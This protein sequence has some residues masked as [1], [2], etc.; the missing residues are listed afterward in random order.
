[1][2]AT[3][4]SELTTSA[5]SSSLARSVKKQTK[6]PA[7]LYV[8]QRGVETTGGSVRMLKDTQEDVG[9]RLGRYCQQASYIKIQ[10]I[11]VEDETN[12]FRSMGMAYD[13]IDDLLVLN[14]FHQVNDILNMFPLESCSSSLLVAILTSTKKAK[15]KIPSRR[16]FFNRAKQS[17]EQSKKLTDGLLTGLE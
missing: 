8:V 7:R 17:L 12:S 11:L 5:P 3:C 9:V 10:N 16:S 6:K 4:Y 13:F 1:M 14:Q 2:Y 15:D